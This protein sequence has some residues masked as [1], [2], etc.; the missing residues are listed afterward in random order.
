MNAAGT[1]LFVRDDLE[2]GGWTQEEYSIDL[3]FPFIAGKVI[4]R[5][6]R[7]CFR[8]PATDSHEVFEV[9]NVQNIEPDHYQQIKAEHIALSEL[10]D[11][12]INTTEITDKTAA[13]ALTTALTGTLWSVGNS[14]VSGT[15]SVDISRGSVWQALLAIAN[16]FNAYIIPR[17]TFSTAGAITGRYIDIV[18]AG[19]TYRGLLLSIDKNIVDSAVIYDDTEVLT[20]LYGYGGSVDVPQTGGAQD[21][22]EELTFKDEVWTATGGHPAKPANQTYL[23]WPEKTALYGRNGRPRYGY[24][25]NSNIKDAAVLLEK[26]W[27]ALQKTCDPNVT[28]SGTVTDIARLGYK[29]Q[30]LRLHD[31]AYIEIRPTGEKLQLEII[32]LYVDFIDPTQTRPEIGAYIPNII[33]I[34]RDTNKKASGGGGGGGRGQTNI[35]HE[36]GET[37]TE[38]VKTQQKIGMVV[39][40]Y[41]GGYKVEGG[42][43]VLSINEQDASTRILLQADIIDIDGVITALKSKSLEVATIEATAAI[44]CLTLDVSQM[45]DCGGITTN[46]GNVYCD[47]TVDTTNLKVA[48]TSAT[49]QTHTV[50]YVTLSSE[51]YFLY[52]TTQST[53]PTGAAQGRVVKG[54]TDKVIHFLGSAATDPS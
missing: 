33:Y 4:L 32:K 2:Q 46:T 10:S 41:N 17:V 9:R 6:M 14:I 15:Q 31:T 50:R 11:E 40:T 13:Q 29:G 54:Y 12:H 28:V 51:V 52:A 8:D 27:E 3:T 16:N 5:G 44:S 38:F 39:G 7:V 49:W 34:N 24:Y 26:T 23:E 43:I 25:Q 22:T 42:Q 37:Y 19:G 21:K 30:P 20:A 18:P 48:E 36:D 1:V 35:E 45:I 47:G 53:T